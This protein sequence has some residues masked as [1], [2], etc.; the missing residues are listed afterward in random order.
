MNFLTWNWLSNYTGQKEIKPK[1][2]MG[3]IEF[4]NHIKNLNRQGEDTSQDIVDFYLRIAFPFMNLMVI[5]LGFPLASKVRTLGFVLGFAIAL[6]SSFVYWGLAQVAKA[7]GH[8]GI[9]PPLFAA[10][11]PNIVFLIVGLILFYKLRK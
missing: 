1:E 10:F 7:F 9:L 8:V 4:K 3:V 5:L 11:M 2:A 6:F